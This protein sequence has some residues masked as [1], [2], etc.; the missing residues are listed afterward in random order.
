MIT[1]R[2]LA[3][4]EEFNA[5]NSDLDVTLKIAM[6]M[7]RH[8]REHV[9]YVLMRD[10]D[11]LQVCVNIAGARKVMDEVRGYLGDWED[12]TGVKLTEE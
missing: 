2:I 10:D 5:R 4:V 7:D 9:V 1:K 3:R 6:L 8:G 11:V 12:I